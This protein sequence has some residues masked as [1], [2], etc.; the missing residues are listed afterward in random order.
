MHM[1]MNNCF[2]KV[3]KTASSRISLFKDEEREK[4]KKKAFNSKTIYVVRLKISHNKSPAV[5]TG[6]KNCELP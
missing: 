2:Q 3:I 5:V 6:F 4:K 1:G